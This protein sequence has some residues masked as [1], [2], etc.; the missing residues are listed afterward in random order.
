[1][2]KSIKRKRNV[3]S[4]QYLIKN[5]FNFLLSFVFRSEEDVYRVEVTH[6]KPEKF[7]DKVYRS[8][9]HE[10]RLEE[11]TCQYHCISLD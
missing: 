1:M 3:S 11:N 9:V 4:T 5:A 8:I 2:E 10:R 7:V 6:E